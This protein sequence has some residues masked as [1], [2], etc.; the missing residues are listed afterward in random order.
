MAVTVDDL[1]THG[2]LPLGLTRLD[3]ATRMIDVLGRHAVPG[4]YGF[5]NGS[6][7]AGAPQ[8]G[9]ILRAWG[10]AG[11]R[12]GNHTFSHLDLTR[13]SVG[14]YVADIERNE[15]VLAE[16][17]S[18]DGRKYFRY[19]YLQ[20]GD[21]RDKRDAVRQWL[22]GHGYTIAQVTVYFEDW[23]WN[24]A[25]ARCVARDDW[26]AVGHLK[27]TFMDAALA[28]LHWSRTV[29]ER[30]LG[31]QIKHILLLHIGAFTSLMMEDLLRAYRAAGTVFI[32]LEE[33]VEDPAYSSSPDIAWNG[34]RTF[35]QQLAEAGADEVPKLRSGVED[36][37]RQCR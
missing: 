32:S 29:S 16:F 1:P 28:R 22:A 8:N 19:P 26:V 2:P 3:I 4:V 17:S 36:L 14:A 27:R 35:L 33:A 12:F 7:L 5:V 20:E 11:L 9:A 13:S 37:A 15:R 18:P 24:D 31:R 25:Y 23:A 30:L 6:Q 10:H 34:E 21:V